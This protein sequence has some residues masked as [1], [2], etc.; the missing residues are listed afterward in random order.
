MNKPENSPL[1]HWVEGELRLVGALDSRMISLLAAIADSGSLNQAAKQVGLSY[2]GA[3]Q[4]IERANN[5]AP[6]ALIVTATGGS[7]GGGTRLTSAGLALVRLFE[8]LT[9]QH[10]AFIEQLNQS[11]AADVD[12]QLLL[13]RL[14]IKTSATNQLFGVITAIEMGAVSAEVVVTLKGGEA[15]V[16]SLAITELESLALAVGS[17]VVLLLNDVEIILASD[18]DH[19][20]LSARN[21]LGGTII[22]IQ[23]DGKD[24][25]VV[26]A[27]ANGDTLS[28]TLSLSSADALA[29]KCGDLAYLVFKG[30][31]VMV[32]A[33]T[34]AQR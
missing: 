25:L 7:K 20:S 2:K 10:Q 34:P 33:Q 4:M 15:I 13:K 14:T 19:W 22:R 1:P 18:F 8:Q 23:Q 3:W 6:K 28:A 26:M 11:L 27:L 32:G 12:M 17:D 24:A 16:V 9:A 29:L 21:C 30:N 31:A 5:L